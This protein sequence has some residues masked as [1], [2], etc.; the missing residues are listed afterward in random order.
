M[1]KK[2]FMVACKLGGD[3]DIRAKIFSML[4]AYITQK[5]DKNVRVA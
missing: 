5:K 2:Q 1:E 4:D 3:P